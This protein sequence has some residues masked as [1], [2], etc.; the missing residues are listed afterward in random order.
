MASN[1]GKGPA[2]VPQVWF[3]LNETMASS[4]FTQKALVLDEVE[5]FSMSLKICLTLSGGVGNVKDYAF[6]IH[7]ESMASAVRMLSDES[8]IAT[9]NLYC[10]KDSVV[11]IIVRRASDPSPNTSCTPS[12]NNSLA[13]RKSASK[14]RGVIAPEL[15]IQ[16]RVR[17]ASESM[18]MV[19]LEKI[20]DERNMV[21]IVVDDEVMTFTSDYLLGMTRAS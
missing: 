14:S 6:Y 8:I 16:Q 10:S 18:D 20:E 7:S 1:K 9:Y 19:T 2:A 4:S 21:S 17:H 11:T 13:S 3:F 15:Y 5:K 12:H